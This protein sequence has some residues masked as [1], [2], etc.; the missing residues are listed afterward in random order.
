VTNASPNRALTRELSSRWPLR[1]AGLW[2]LATAKTL[3]S[4]LPE[5]TLLT[6]VTRLVAAAEGE[7]LR[8]PA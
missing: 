2:H 7:G 3:Q 1:G 8:R 4:D 6:F 5:L